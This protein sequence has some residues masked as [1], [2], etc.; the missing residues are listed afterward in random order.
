MLSSDTAHLTKRFN[1]G[2]T[3]RMEDLDTEVKII[4]ELVR[5]PLMEWATTYLMFD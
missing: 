3:V 2:V 1:A 5:D 4:A